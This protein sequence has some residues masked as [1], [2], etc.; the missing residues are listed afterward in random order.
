MARQSNQ[1]YQ[2]LTVHSAATSLTVPHLANVAVI[3]VETQAV[4]MR[5]DGTDPTASIGFPLAT[6]T[7]FTYDGELSRL[8]LIAQ[9][10]TATVNV[11]YF[12]A[13]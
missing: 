3:S 2:Q 6:G 13:V 9:T 4:R 8:K 7:P 1:G 11:W 5:D 12:L 10:G